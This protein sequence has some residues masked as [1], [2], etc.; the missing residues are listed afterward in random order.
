MSFTYNDE[1]RF[2]DSPNLDGFSRLRTSQPFNIFS[3]SNTF[4]SGTTFYETIS[5]GSGS[6]TFNQSKSEIQFNVF[7]NADYVIREQHGYNYYQPGKSQL[8]FMTGVFGTL[9][10][11]TYKKMGYYNDSDGL[12]FQSSG[13]TFGIT[14]RTSTSGSVVDTFIPQSEWNL[15]TLDTG[16]T[17]NP[18]G[19]HLDVSKTNIYVIN[20][21]WLGVGRVNFA[22]DIDGQIVPVH[23]ILNANNKTEV[24]MKTPNLPVRYE[25]ISSGGTDSTFK[26]ICASVISEGGQEQ[27]GFPSVVSNGLVTRTFTTRQ[28][29]LSVRL[30]SS[31]QGNTNRVVVVPEAI[32][33]LSTTNTVNAYWELI[34]QRVIIGENNLGGSP[35]WL[36]LSG[37]PL[38]YSVNGTTVSGGI[39]LDSGYFST[40]NQSG[41]RNISSILKTKSIMSLD[42]AG[43]TSDWLH[44]VVTPSVTSSWST[45]IKLTSKF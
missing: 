35:T 26:Q 12:I 34:L 17:L 43:A 42:Y 38:E 9:A 4:T 27:F 37:T 25:V 7:G 14:L 45:S 36:P 15:D 5:D 18:S 44:L 22:V 2:S 10:S 6:T 33:L 39:V 30:N 29:V 23:E 28:S 1:I 41:V 20:F 40:T 13:S 32:D 31:F 21:Q 8:I 3:S 16:N 24:Y 11:D 19:I